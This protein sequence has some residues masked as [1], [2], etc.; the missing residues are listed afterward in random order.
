MSAR[1]PRLKSAKYSYPAKYFKK[2]RY[3]L[4]NLSSLPARYREFKEVNSK[5]FV[6]LSN[7]VN[8]ERLI[9]AD[10]EGLPP[11]LPVLE[12]WVRSIRNKFPEK[13]LVVMLDKLHFYDVPGCDPGDSRIRKIIAFLNRLTAEQHCTILAP[14]GLPHAASGK[15]GQIVGGHAP[16]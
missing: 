13:A 16:G 5:A 12:E 7:L 4:K 3:Y 14:A 6:W 1:I 9:L 15:R 10:V 8:S 11:Q 2:A